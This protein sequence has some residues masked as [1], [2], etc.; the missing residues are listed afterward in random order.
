M[1][2]CLLSALTVAAASW[3]TTP[4]AADGTQLEILTSWNAALT[5][6]WQSANSWGVKYA[7]DTQATEQKWMYNDNYQKQIKSPDGWCVTVSDRGVIS[8]GRPVVLVV[9]CADNT[10]KQQWNYDTNKLTFVNVDM[11]EFCLDAD[12]STGSIVQV[13]WCTDG[14]TNQQWS[15]H[16][17]GYYVTKDNKCLT[18][19]NQWKYSDVRPK[20]CANSPLQNWKYNFEEGY[21]T[22]GMSGSNVCL[23]APTVGEEKS[24]HLWDCDASVQNQHIDFDVISSDNGKTTGNFHIRDTTLC[25]TTAGDG[26]PLTTAPCAS[27]PSNHFFTISTVKPWNDKC[28]GVMCQNGGVCVNGNCRCPEGVHGSKCE[29][30]AVYKGIQASTGYFL[31]VG[32]S[33]YDLV[34]AAPDLSKRSQLFFHDVDNTN[35]I[36]VKDRLMCLEAAQPNVKLALCSGSEMQKWWYNVQMGLLQVDHHNLCLMTTKASPGSEQT[37]RVDTCID[38]ESPGQIWQEPVDIYDPTFLIRNRNDAK[39]CWAITNGKL[40]IA[41]CNLNAELQWKF[42]GYSGAGLLRQGSVCAQAQLATRLNPKSSVIS[43]NCDTQENNQQFEYDSTSGLLRLASSTMCVVLTSDNALSIATCSSADAR[44]HWYVPKRDYCFMSDFMGSDGCNHGKCEFGGCQC[45]TGYSGLK[46]TRETCSSLEC[47]NNGTCIQGQCSCTDGYT[48]T[49]CD[50]FVKCNGIKCLHGGSCTM[51]GKCT[52]PVGFSGDRCQKKHPKVLL[53]TLDYR[54]VGLEGGRIEVVLPDKRVDNHLWLWDDVKYMLR[55]VGSPTYCMERTAMGEV[56]VGGCDLRATE[57]QWL[58]LP[59][60]GSI[61]AKD[62]SSYFGLEETLAGRFKVLA[63]SSGTSLSNSTVTKMF[64]EMDRL[65]RPGMP[66]RNSDLT[67]CLQYSSGGSVT[68]A[69]C[70]LEA[71]TQLWEYHPQNGVIKLPLLGSPLCIAQQGQS[72]SME[73]CDGDK[74]AQQFSYDWT[75]K[76]YRN[77]QTLDCLA[78]SGGGLAMASCALNTSN[79]V[80]HAYFRSFCDVIGLCGEGHCE[81][82]Q[83]SCPEGMAGEFCEK[84]LT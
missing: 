37:L 81:F 3:L 5:R 36:K 40:Q 33:N 75:T 23:D 58:Y 80:F 14:N 76:R 2:L 35:E 82:E 20:D 34:T 42:E 1:K 61:T 64:V 41:T 72:V 38:S 56:S 53:R 10:P 63:L 7:D 28:S 79:Q 27:L 49:Y 21:L 4:V 26:N 19:D 30:A 60:T 55:S 6:F 84:T 70:D 44:Q 73:T 39:A 54:S 65:D 17:N 59:K 69:D 50:D 24:A 29:T 83:C 25:I 62:S 45:E 52:C 46:C 78:Y 66:V 31:T 15:L 74:T 51:E 8:D 67:K 18:A 16:Y 71:E 68:F 57:Q 22:L 12:K 43:A 11:N 77:R 13:Y 47:S 48:G 9:S 32:S